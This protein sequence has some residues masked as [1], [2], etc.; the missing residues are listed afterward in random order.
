MNE[1]KS[2]AKIEFTT[3][4]QNVFDDDGTKSM[5]YSSSTSVQSSK[6]KLG[7]GSLVVLT[8]Y[9]VSGGPFGIEDIVKAGAPFYAL[10]GFGLMLI[11]SLPEALITAELSTALPESSGSVAW[12]EVAFGSFWAFQKGYLSWLSGIADNALY[13]ILFLD[14]ILQLFSKCQT[15]ESGYISSTTCYEIQELTDEKNF[16]RL[17]IIF[18]ITLILTFS[19]AWRGLEIVSSMSIFVCIFSLLPF[20]I[21]CIKGSFHVVPSR[22]LI[23]PVGGISGVNWYV[24]HF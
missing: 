2:S 10:L 4:Y 20:I 9:S 23:Q 5:I 15:E 16:F 7:I 18:I 17:A 6:K 1:E 12:I 22:W 8:F 11:W 14:C 19:F 13:P 24:H 21:F 3:S